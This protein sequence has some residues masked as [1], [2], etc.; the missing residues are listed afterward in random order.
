MVE[1]DVVVLNE[2]GLHVRTCGKFGSSGVQSEP[3][4]TESREGITPVPAIPSTRSFMVCH[5]T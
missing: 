3:D 4:A 5:C 1:A 2:S